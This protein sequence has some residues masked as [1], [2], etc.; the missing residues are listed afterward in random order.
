MKS[1]EEKLLKYGFVKLNYF[2]YFWYIVLH[3]RGVSTK[4]NISKILYA[5]MNIGKA[6]SLVMECNDMWR[7][8]KTKK[9]LYISTINS[10][11]YRLKL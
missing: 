4:T 10:Q 11:I 2:W 7:V 3:H 1:L 6:K 5:E 9:Y 8:F